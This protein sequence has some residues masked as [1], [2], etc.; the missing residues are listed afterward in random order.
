VT[1]AVVH[2]ALWEY[3]TAVN[4]SPEPADQEKLRREI[5]DRYTSKMTL[6]FLVSFL[7][8][9]SC[10]EV[11]AEMVHTKDGSR[12]VREF[13]AQGTAKVSASDLNMLN[14]INVSDRIGNKS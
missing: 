13:L 2:R 3:L 4:T 8:L 5:F 11:L 6:H 12:V 7:S 14:F 9:G 1:H 10:Q